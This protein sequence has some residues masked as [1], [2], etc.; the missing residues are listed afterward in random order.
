[1]QE[2]LTKARDEVKNLREGTPV[3]KVFMKEGGVE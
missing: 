2:E 3:R 1:L